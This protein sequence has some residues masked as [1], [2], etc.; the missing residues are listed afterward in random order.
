MSTGMRRGELLGLKWTDVDFNQS[1][2]AVR[3][4]L[5]RGQLTTPKNGK[6]R[7]IAM[8]PGLGSTLLDLL[9]TRRRESLHK[10]WSENPEWVFC[11]KTGGQLDERNFTRTWYR[12]RRRAQKLGVRPLKLHCTRHTYARTALAAGKSLRWVAHQNPEFTLRTYAHLMPQEETDLS[13]ADFGVPKRP[14]TA[15]TSEAAAANENAPATSGR[16]HSVLMKHETRFEFIGSTASATAS[17]A[18]PTNHSLIA[19]DSPSRWHALKPEG[20]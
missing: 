3:Q 16:G 4:A 20:L 11:S 8:S 12:V 14:Y 18:A 5:V 6:G 15:P 17:P 9:G 13:F 7:Q 2:I 19:R 1:R 10:S